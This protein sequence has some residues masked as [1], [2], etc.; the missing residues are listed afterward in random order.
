MQH[1]LVVGVNTAMF[2]GVEP[3]TAFRTVCE[4]G[5]TFIELAYNQGY[6]GQLS[7]F[8]FSEQNAARVKALLAQYGLR[9]QALGC[10]MNLADSNAV[11][12]FRKRIDFARHTGATF[13]N[14]CIGRR[15]DRDV[16]IANL[17]A[18]APIAQDSGCV[19]CI[20]NGGDPD[21]DVFA[22]AEE[23]MALLEAVNSPALAFNVDA[24]NTV[25]LRPERDAINEACHMLPGARHCH[26]KD[27]IKKDGECFFPAIG[28]GMLDYAPL[29]RELAQRQIPC[30]L[31]IPLRM[32]RMRDT[33]PRRA[34][35]P[36]E[37]SV[38]LDVLLRSRQAL[39]AML[40]YAL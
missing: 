26:I 3:E 29:L 18:L 4:A 19:I 8:L 40:G 34:D 24:G 9:T 32:H 2:D 33:L 22:V 21:Y 6:V 39:E 5:F 38:S 10:T 28:E 14:A 17:K 12:E 36:V 7:P 20:E 27:V 31:E 23:G 25:S 1:K 16:I 30:S 11:T 37:P 13:L 35:R 15:R